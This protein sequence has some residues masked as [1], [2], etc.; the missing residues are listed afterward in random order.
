MKKSVGLEG[1]IKKASGSE[2]KDEGTE[3]RKRKNGMKAGE[4][5]KFF[6]EEIRN[7]F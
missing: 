2:L 5:E 1:T 4:E 7:E 3:E 6:S